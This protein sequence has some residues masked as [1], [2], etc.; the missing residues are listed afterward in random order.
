MQYSL[1]LGWTCVFMVHSGSIVA[2]TQLFVLAISGHGQFKSPMNVVLV[3]VMVVLGVHHV[4]C[5]FCSFFVIYELFVSFT[6]PGFF[7]HI[8]A[9]S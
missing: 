6:D 5:A 3:L 1:L 7:L 9:V 2:L 8:L 4:L